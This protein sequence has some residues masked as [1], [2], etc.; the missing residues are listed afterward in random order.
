MASAQPTRPPTSGNPSIEIT[1]TPGEYRQLCRDLRKLR[2]AGAASNTA[3]IL[4]AVQAAA[5]GHILRAPNK[6]RAAR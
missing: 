2:S 6:S 1:P 3:A 5:T 4:E